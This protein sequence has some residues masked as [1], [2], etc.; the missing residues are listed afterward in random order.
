MTYLNEAKKVIDNEIKGIIEVASKLNDSFEQLI[1]VISNSKG[2]LVMCG[3]GKSGHIAKKMFAT[4]VST[5][6]PSMYMH[7][8]EAFHGD[9]GM[10]QENDIFFAISNSGETSEVTQLLPFIKANG[11]ILISMTGNPESTLGQIS[12]FHL[13]IGVEK[14]A[15]PLNLAP[16]TSTTVSL[17]LG[18][19]IAV[20]LMKASNFQAE[21]FAKYHP[22]GALGRKLLLT[23]KDTLLPANFVSINDDIISV[24]KSMSLS[25]SGIILVGNASDL[26]GV[27][28]DGDIR[29]ALAKA[30]PNEV[31]NILASD[32]MSKE[33]KTV[34]AVCRC[35]DAD[36]R[37]QNEGINSLIVK[38]KDLILG[39]YDNLNRKK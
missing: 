6:T 4:F 37:M 1:E 25:S 7:P 32:I 8:A 30:E 13:D 9:L 5:G 36:I 12:D 26:I 39:V 11:N 17:V 18:D 29:L 22:G 33:P 34:S 20:A 10:I 15:C 27:I 14:E 2:R 38:D 3:M 28:T 24:L 35:G 31:C 21:N 16:T 19:A 23:V